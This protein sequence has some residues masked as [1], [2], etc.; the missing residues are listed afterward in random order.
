MVVSVALL[1]VFGIGKVLGSGGGGDNNVSKATTTASK[2]KHS[3]APLTLGPTTVV[4]TGKT[5]KGKG[6][7]P[8]VPLAT[9]SG[10]CAADEVTVTPTITKAP[11]GGTVAVGLSLTGTA[12][13]CTFTVSSKTVVVKITSGTDRIWSSQDCPRSIP[14]QVVV[15]RSAAPATATVNWSGRRSDTGCPNSTQWAGPG[16]YHATAAAL[17][18]TAGDDAQFQLTLPPRPVVTR[19][20]HP[21]PQKTPT[22]TPT[23]TPTHH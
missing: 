12:A 10:L 6:H 17:G 2:T 3:T 16:Y 14:R 11:A 15:V 1:L 19:T 20:T 4:T 13:A 9:P 18:S 5:G 8:V 22:T 23:K 7:L 21:K